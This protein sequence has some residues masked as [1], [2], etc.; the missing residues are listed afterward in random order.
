MADVID[1]GPG[2]RLLPFSLRRVSWG[3]VFAG[4]FVGV[5]IGLTLNFI[6]SAIFVHPSATGGTR[7]LG[8]GA[9]IWFIVAMLVSFFIGGWVAGRLAG[10]P[11]RGTGSLHGLVAWSLAMVALAVFLVAGTGTLL[12]N[13]AT[14]VGSTEQAAGEAAS[15]AMGTA[16]APTLGAETNPSGAEQAAK[17]KL[18]RAGARLEA[19]IRDVSII[20]SIMLV[21]S[22]LCSVW[23]GAAGAPNEV[24]V[25]P[26]LA[27][28]PEEPIVEEKPPRRVA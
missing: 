7:G 8:I 6:G 27:G 19:G 24:L 18:N 17:A 16:P 11:N 28:R 5:A 23:G 26:T 25:A 9:F 12:T 13:A 14:L 21:L 15:G 20:A 2:M 1:A 3:A 10:V 4:A 22:C